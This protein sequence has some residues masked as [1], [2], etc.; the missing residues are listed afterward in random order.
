M[1]IGYGD[2]V[3][4]RKEVCDSLNDWHRQR[5]P[6][7]QSTVSKT[8]FNSIGKVKKL[9]KTGR[10]RPQRTKLLNKKMQLIERMA[11][12]HKICFQQDGA[13]LHYDRRVRNYL[14]VNVPN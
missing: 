3:R 12:Y 11:S 1:A 9:P 10:L 13:P 5:N 2:L 6:I 7:S 4:N 14:D 8:F